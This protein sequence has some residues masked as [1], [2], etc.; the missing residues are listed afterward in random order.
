[1][2][3]WHDK[4][5]SEGLVIVNIFHGPTDALYGINVDDIEAHLEEEKATFPVL[6]DSDG[7]TCEAYGVRGYP[8]TYLLGRDGK[9]IW[10]PWWFSESRSERAIVKALQTQTESD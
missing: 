3:K 9:V 10:E 7:S 6:Y 4:Y 2:V 5:S 8:S 1:M